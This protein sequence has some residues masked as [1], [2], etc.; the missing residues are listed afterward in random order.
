[1]RWWVY[2]RPHWGWFGRKSIDT[3]LYPSQEG[4]DNLLADDVESTSEVS[5]PAVGQAHALLA[6]DVIIP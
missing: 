6:D 5:S 3:A 4:V 2:R 1:M